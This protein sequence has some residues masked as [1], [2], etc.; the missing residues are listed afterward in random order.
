ME[1]PHPKP[2]YTDTENRR[3]KELRIDAKYKNRCTFQE[4]VWMKAS[5]DECKFVGMPADAPSH[6]AKGHLKIHRHECKICHMKFFDELEVYLHFSTQC[7]ASKWDDMNSRLF[8]RDEAITHRRVVNTSFEPSKREKYYEY[9]KLQNQVKSV[10]NQEPALPSTPGYD[11]VVEQ[12]LA[13]AQMAAASGSGHR[14]KSTNGNRCTR[15]RKSSREPQ[16]LET[17]VRSLPIAMRSR[18]ASIEHNYPEGYD[19]NARPIQFGYIPRDQ[20]GPSSQNQ[21]RQPLQDPRLAAQSQRSDP[22]WASPMETLYPEEPDTIMVDPTP[23]PEA[24]PSLIDEPIPLVF[25]RPPPP[26]PSNFNFNQPPPPIAQPPPVAPQ[27]RVDLPRASRSDWTEM[28]R[29]TIAP[30]APPAAEPPRPVPAPANPPGRSA[31]LLQAAQP[32]SVAPQVHVDPPRASRSDWTET[33]PSTIAAAAPP[34]AQPSRSVPGPIG[35]FG[36]SAPPPPAAPPI[37]PQIRVDPPRET[38]PSTIAQPS[39]SAAPPAPIPPPAAQQSRSVPVPP[40][41]AS[42]SPAPTR[43]DLSERTLARLAQIAPSSQAAQPESA[44][45]QPRRQITRSDFEGPATRTRGRSRGGSMDTSPVFRQAPRRSNFRARST[46]GDDARTP[47]PRAKSRDPEATPRRSAA[48]NQADNDVLGAA[49]PLTAREQSTDGS[50]QPVVKRGRGRPRRDQSVNRPDEG[51]RG[52][53]PEPG[54]PEKPVGRPRGGSS[55]DQS[56]EPEGPSGPTNGRPRVPSREPSVDAQPPRRGPGRPRTISREPSEDRDTSRERVAG[57]ATAA[58]MKRNP[59]FSRDPSRDRSSRAPSVEASEQVIVAER[60][61][62]TG[63]TTNAI[64][65]PGEFRAGPK[66]GVSYTRSRSRDSGDEGGMRLRELAS[67]LSSD[68]ADSAA[69]HRRQEPRFQAKSTVKVA[70]GQSRMAALLDDVPSMPSSV[71]K[72][73][74]S[75]RL[76]ATREGRRQAAYNR[77][78][79]AENGNG[80][81]ETSRANGS[82]Q[83]EKRSRIRTPGPSVLHAEIPTPPGIGWIGG[84]PQ[85]KR[86][87]HHSPEPPVPGTSVQAPPSFAPGISLPSASRRATPSGDDEDRPAW[88]GPSTS[89]P[90]TA[91]HRRRGSTT[92]EVGVPPPHVFSPST[93]SSYVHQAPPPPSTSDAPAATSSSFSG[94]YVDLAK[95]ALV[96][97][98]RQDIPNPLASPED[99]A[100]VPAHLAEA[101]RADLEEYGR[102]LNERGL[103]NLPSTSTAPLPSAGGFLNLPTSP[104]PQPGVL[105]NLSR[106]S[107]AVQSRRQILGLQDINH[108]QPPPERHPAQSFREAA[109]QRVQQQAEQAHQTSRRRQSTER[110]VRRQSPEVRGGEG[111]SSDRPHRKRQESRRWQERDQGAWQGGHYR[112]SRSRDDDNGGGW[113]HVHGR[114]GARGQGNYLGRNFDPHYHERQR[115]H[116]DHNGGGGA[117]RRY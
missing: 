23:E 43:I 91:H 89:S 114:G 97:T 19:P 21:Q 61:G 110:E 75:T 104:A 92:S 95:M 2:I 112:R 4:C 50:G 115:D 117:Y 36:R 69:H 71:R 86:P 53:T 76:E 29:S 52:Q 48:F 93:S 90:S 30:A 34:A 73:T 35:P 116:R 31:P 62:R 15:P 94:L 58:G 103:Q 81:V 37:P 83:Q 3:L 42:S 99:V 39:Q 78:R 72:P 27:V 96:S 12:T 32:P 64:K 1:Q 5:H 7:P 87:R 67:T 24:D 70:C 82:T 113:N 16:V 9:Q 38:K 44:P 85:E 8:S 10:S 74:S 13:A 41:A 40:A 84:E 17:S 49:T 28:K 66:R 59:N 55:R 79:V 77:L 63:T 51:P 18:E 54:R 11:D 25:N 22:R 14:E 101:R 88:N 26:I 80:G 46:D 60:V 57:V 111:S 68:K 33:K 100:P 106:A 105:Q 98:G 102:R 6:I 20:A 108:Y 109:L 107:E 65:T 47:A 45:C 56:R